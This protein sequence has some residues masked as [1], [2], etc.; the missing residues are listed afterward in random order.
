[1]IACC[2]DGNV[3]GIMPPLH[4][5]YNRSICI[6][7]YNMCVDVDWRWYIYMC[8]H[9]DWK[10]TLSN[11]CTSHTGQ[12]LDLNTLKLHETTQVS[13]NATNISFANA[14]HHFHWIGFCQD[15]WHTHNVGKK[16]SA[17]GMPRWIY[18]Y[19]DMFVSQFFCFTSYQIS[20]SSAWYVYKVRCI[21]IYMHV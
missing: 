5:V 15:L 4:N 8:I 11:G 16:Q 18:V 19:N 10:C 2:N 17:Q 12:H 14:T 21:Y 13:M 1:M 9:V 7:K 6:D 20:K 3:Y